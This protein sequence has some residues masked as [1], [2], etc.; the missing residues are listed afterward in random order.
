MRPIAPGSTARRIIEITQ[1]AAPPIATLFGERRE[2][3]LPFTHPGANNKLGNSIGR[4]RIEESQQSP[5]V[6][7]KGEI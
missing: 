4:G 6:P 5:K 3:P 1:M 7:P 2:N